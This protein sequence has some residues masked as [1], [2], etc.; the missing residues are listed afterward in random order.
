MTSGLALFA[1]CSVR[2]AC[3]LSLVQ[4]RRSVRVLICT[5]YSI[6]QS[7]TSVQ[8]APISELLRFGLSCMFIML[9]RALFKQNAT[10]NAETS[11]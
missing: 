4:L 2:Q 6:W 10:G 8:L 9:D 7:K 5:D 11:E 1:R 3:H